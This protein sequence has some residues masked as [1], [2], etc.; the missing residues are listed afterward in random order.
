MRAAIYAWIL[1]RERCWKVE[2]QRTRFVHRLE[3][4]G[5]AQLGGAR[6]ECLS[7][8]LPASFGRPSSRLIHCPGYLSSVFFTPLRKPLS[9]SVK[10]E[11]GGCREERELEFPV[12]V[13][14]RLS[15]MLDGG[16]WLSIVVGKGWL[17]LADL[18]YPRN[19]ALWLP[20]DAH[21]TPLLCESSSTSV[22]R[23]V[24][25]TALL[26]IIGDGPGDLPALLRFLLPSSLVSK[27]ETSVIQD[28]MEMKDLLLAG[29]HHLDVSVQ[30]TAKGHR[31]QIIISV[32]L[33]VRDQEESGL[34]PRSA[35]EQL[36]KG[37]LHRIAAQLP[38][39]HSASSAV[40]LD[41]QEIDSRLAEAQKLTSEES[42]ARFLAEHLTPL[43]PIA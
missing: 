24:F 12:E 32:A 36:R 21:A 2:K 5:W 42:R 37:I 14:T 15:R 22:F 30:A 17:S 34:R 20:S 25:T 13:T 33:L 41:L 16:Q 18:L 4:L 29:H 8:L 27:A 40:H 9:A 3:R 28:G 39:L 1:V 38:S 43:L 6:G 19:A 35:A 11:R 23:L 10:W 7:Q 31:A 26:T